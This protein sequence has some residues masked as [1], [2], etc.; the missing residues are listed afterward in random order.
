MCPVVRCKYSR[1]GFARKDKLRSH[2]KIV[3]RG[4]AGPGIR[5]GQAI[6][7]KGQDGL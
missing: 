3:H 7:A 1:G 5:A 4:E 6:R 2:V